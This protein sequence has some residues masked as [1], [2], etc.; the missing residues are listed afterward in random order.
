MIDDSG[1]NINNRDRA[2]F[3][4]SPEPSPFSYFTPNLLGGYVTY[5]VDLSNLPCGCITAL[6][7]VM[8]PARQ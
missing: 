8:M 2:Y 7:S 1:I 4:T 5:D 3:S 6:Y